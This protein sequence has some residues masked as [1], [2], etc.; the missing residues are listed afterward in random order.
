MALEPG[1]L[2][3]LEQELN[4]LGHLGDDGVL[5]TDHLGHIDAG[6]LDRNAM[7]IGMVGD[8]LEL[9]AR[10]QQGLRRNTADVQAGATQDG[11]TGRVDPL[12]DAGSGE[13]QL[14]CAN[15]GDVAG[16]AGPNDD[17]VK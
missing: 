15:G 4:A 12:L 14:C 5:A 1:D 9:F 6:A 16:W 13:S 11:L 17:D 2:V 3:L 7:H 10:G 8:L